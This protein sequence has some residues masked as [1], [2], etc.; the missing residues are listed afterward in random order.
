MKYRKNGFSLI[1]L[2]VAI[3]LVGTALAALS[4]TIMAFRLRQTSNFSSI[5]YALAEEEM[6]S[7]KAL[8]FASLTN[9][10][11]TRF[12]NVVYNLGKFS[13]QTN[14]ASSS[15]PNVYAA[16]ATGTMAINNLTNNKTLPLN[17]GSI[18]SGSIKIRYPANPPLNWAGGILFRASDLNN[19]YRLTIESNGLI[20]K[21]VV[22]G[23]TTTL[24]TYSFTPTPNTWY[25]MTINAVGTAITAYVNGTNI[26]TTNDS[27]LQS[28]KIAIAA[29][30]SLLPLFDN[31]AVSLDGAASSTWNFDTSST[32]GAD[33]APFKKFGVYDLPEGKDE[34]TIADY[35]GQADIK[36][37]TVKISWK[38]RG[39]AKAIQLVALRHG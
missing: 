8:P 23:V 21:K 20:L 22:N 17:D 34:L 12:I 30:N 5:A 25:T 18:V 11:S 32:V 38:E 7:I 31:L 2:I 15:P 10:S 29:F 35:L 16:T 37:I 28:G 26:G 36:Q 4:A 19:Y 13:V 3:A 39:T 9:T 14:A 24:N 1:E 33:F 27:D 6:V